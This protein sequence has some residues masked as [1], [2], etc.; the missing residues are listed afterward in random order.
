MNYELHEIFEN[1]ELGIIL[2][3]NCSI[4]FSNH[5]FKGILKNI[6]ILDNETDKVKDSILDLRIF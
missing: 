2:V 4:S 6:N 3:Q 1:L 5:I